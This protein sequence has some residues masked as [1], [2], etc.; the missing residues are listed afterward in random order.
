MTAQQTFTGVVSIAG[1]NPYVDVPPA[2]VEAVGGSKAAVLVKVA[3]AGR[4]TK[5]RVRLSASEKVRL[6]AI[7]RLAAPN[8]FRTTLVP[9]R[10]TPTRLYL[11]TWMRKTAGLDVGDRARVTLK[12]DRG[13][14]ELAVPRPLQLALNR[15]R[16]A[17]AAWKSAA[18]SRRRQILLYLNALTSP[19]ALAKNVER[20]VSALLTPRPRP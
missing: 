20:A 11:D 1:I 12:R 10:A 2:V 8:W 6:T 18:P 5:P 19:E 9:A 13:P 14:R 17:K 15:N 3:A 4:S 7:R 16:E